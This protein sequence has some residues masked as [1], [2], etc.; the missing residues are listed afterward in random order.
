MTYYEFY[1]KNTDVFQILANVFKAKGLK[2]DVELGDSDLPRISGSL[3][4]SSQGIYIR[5][6]QYHTLSDEQYEKINSLFPIKIKEYTLR[7]HG[8]SDYEYD[9]DRMWE[10][11]VSFSFYKD[12][13]N[14]LD[15]YSLPKERHW[16][17]KSHFKQV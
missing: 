11:S 15:R 16:S 5:I 10:P 8:I 17:D 13:I 6:R 14:V 4:N 9:D 3:S 7:L 1:N 12:N 2:I